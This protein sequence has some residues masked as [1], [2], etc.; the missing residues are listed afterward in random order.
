[1]E[2]LVTTDRRFAAF[3]K[4]ALPPRMNSLPQGGMC[5]SAFLVVS[6]RGE[7]GNVLMGRINK[8][9][10]WDHIG[11]LDGK[12]V[13]RFA[14]GWML[15]SSHL[16]LFETPEGAAR[17]ILREQL[18]I[19]SQ[20]LGGPLAFSDTSGTS[21]HWDL[22]FIFTGERETSPSS[23]AWDELKFVEVAKLKR[24][25]IVRSQLDVLTYAGKLVVR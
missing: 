8:N 1:V 2:D 10:E 23:A 16:M 24:D 15:P 25:E 22:G 7:P 21:N 17:R 6:K 12:R 18:G 4:D 20:T 13:E 5:I 3:S 14:S 9:A 19:R 11:A